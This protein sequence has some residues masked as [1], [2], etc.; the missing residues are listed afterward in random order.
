MSKHVKGPWAFSYDECM[1][2]GEGE[3]TDSKDNALAIIT[4]PNHGVFFGGYTGDWSSVDSD[5]EDIEIH[6][7][8]AK[9]IS[10]APDMYDT[11]KKLIDELEKVDT[12]YGYNES[13]VSDAKK[14]IEYVDGE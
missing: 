12:Y 6:K 1:R 2:Y 10:K 9:I 14:L 7:A 11:V 4:G 8:N 3:I 13:V 5:A